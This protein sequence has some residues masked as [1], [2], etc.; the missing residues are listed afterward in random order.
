MLMLSC[1][2]EN[3]VKSLQLEKQNKNTDDYDVK[4]D[5]DRM[6]KKNEHLTNFI[7]GNDTEKIF[8]S[9]Q[10][11][12]IKVKFKI[13]KIILAQNCNDIIIMI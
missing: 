12:R 4:L 3:F 1:I 8:L 6:A 2:H 7:K 11:Q 9:G 10:S 13:F 5:D